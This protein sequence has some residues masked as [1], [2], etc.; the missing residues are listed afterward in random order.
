[1]RV[2]NKPAAAGAKNAKGGPAAAG[3]N[4]ERGGGEG[5][6]HTPNKQ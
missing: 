6:G 1:M 5:A 2:I 4:N 3:N